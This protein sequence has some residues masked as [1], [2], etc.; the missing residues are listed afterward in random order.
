MCA[1]LCYVNSEV[2]GRHWVPHFTILC[3]SP[4]RRHF[5]PNP[6][7]GWQPAA[8]SNPPVSAPFPYP[9]LV[10]Q[11]FWVYAQA[12][13]L[14]LA[15]GLSVWIYAQTTVHHCWGCR[16]E[17]I[18][19]QAPIPYLALG[20]EVWIYV[21]TSIPYPGARIAGVDLSSSSHSVPGAGVP[22]MNPC[23]DFHP[24]SW[25]WGCRCESM[26]KLPLYTWC[27]G[28]RCVS[29]CPT[30]FFFLSLEVTL[31]LLWDTVV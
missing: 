16:C 12:P 5:S 15:P 17:S 29:L 26:S 13:I 4:R 3:I 1:G 28:C 21:Q 6:E 19:A 14:Y 2:R 27:W 25:C 23:P 22:N 20:L 24:L 30:F 9:L 7:L 8:P 31:L 18:Y 11:V 10:L